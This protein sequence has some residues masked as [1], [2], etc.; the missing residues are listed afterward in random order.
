MESKDQLSSTLN[1]DK[2][3]ERIIHDVAKRLREIGDDIDCEYSELRLD[4]PTI[5]DTQLANIIF[6]DLKQK[7]EFVRRFLRT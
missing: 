4:L 5:I 7:F 2:D 1:P 6:G 3:Q